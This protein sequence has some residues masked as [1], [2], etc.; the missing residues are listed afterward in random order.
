MVDLL[1]LYLSLELPGLELTCTSLYR[2]EEENKAIYAPHPP[3]DSPHLRW[4][5]IDFRSLDLTPEQIKKI[6]TFCNIF[7]YR[8]G[9]PVAI[10]HKIAGGAEHLHIQFSKT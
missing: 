8:G 3:S 4:E 2:T 1:E 7:T 6:L 10:H 5:A 9:L